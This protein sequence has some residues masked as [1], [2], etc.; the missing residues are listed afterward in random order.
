MQTMATEKKVYIIGE[1]HDRMQVFLKELDARGVPTEVWNTSRGAIVSTLPP[2]PGV[3]YCRQS[4]SATGRGNPHAAAYAR[5]ILRW[6]EFHGSTVVNGCKALDT[7]TSKSLQ[8]MAMHAANLN[9]PFT[10]VQQGVVQ[11]VTEAARFTVPVILKPNHGG[12]GRGVQSFDC[13]RSAAAAIKNL[14][15]ADRALAPDSLWC[16][17]A[18]LGKYTDDETAV[19]SIL[20]IEVIGGLVQRDYILKITAP[21]KEFSLCPCDPRGAALLDRISFMVLRNPLTIPGFDGDDA[22]FDA[23]CKKIEAA[24]RLCSASVGSVEAVVLWEDDYASALAYP[25]PH[26]PVLFEMNFNTNYNERAE[27]AAGIKSGVLRVV[28]MLQAML[29]GAT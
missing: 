27:A 8:V 13:G 2:P 20:R 23:F 18:L 15:G 3:F 26:E 14:S 12:S 22:K 29:E 1:D 16:L 17:Q 9:T 4:P 19:R 24:F 28:D 25:T 5:E 7:E 21:C 6:L 11:T 10:I